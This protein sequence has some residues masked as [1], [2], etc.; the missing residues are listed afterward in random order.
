MS[1]KIIAGIALLLVFIALTVYIIV[2]ISSNIPPVGLDTGPGSIFQFQEPYPGARL[3]LLLL[4]IA[5][6][7]SF[8]TGIIL[9]AMGSGES[10]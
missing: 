3:V 7:L 9:I 4:V 10:R 1:K 6:L 2:T 8:L 5:A